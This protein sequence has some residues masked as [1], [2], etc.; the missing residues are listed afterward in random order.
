MDACHVPP[1]ISLF[2]SLAYNYF[3]HTA[4]TGLL[5]FNARYYDPAAG[6]FITADTTLS[7]GGTDP[8]ALSR[9]AYVEGN[10]LVRLDPSGH[11]WFGSLVSTVT[12]EVQ[13]AAPAA[14]AVLD[15]TTGIPSM[16]T[17]VHTIFFSTASPMDKIMAGA[18]LI[19]NVTM[20]VTMVIGVGEG[21][22]AAY[23]GAH[24]VE[25]VAEDVGA[26]ALE[27]AGEDAVA[28]T[29]EHEAESEAEHASEHA[30]EDGAEAGCGLSFAASTPVATPAGAKPIASLKTGDHVLAYDPTTGTAGTQTVTATSIHHD[31]NL[32]D[33][34][35]LV[36]DPAT[37]GSSQTKARGGIGQ[38]QTAK[39]PSTA[40]SSR[41]HDEIV[42]TTTNHPWLTTG[43]GWLPASFLQV[44]EPVVELDGTTATV[45]AIH[46][47]AGAASMWDLSVS[48]IHTFAVGIGEYVVHNC[49][50]SK[51]DF[52]DEKQIQHEYKHAKDFGVNGNYNMANSQAFRDALTRHIEDPD[53]VELT[54]GNAFGK[55]ATHY[56]C[57]SKYRRCVLC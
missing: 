16:I 21:L 30:V 51:V 2:F 3:I 13:T 27:H 43:H 49:D 14:V 15:A 17:D 37:S 50:A 26:H 36:N 57:H 25:Q 39:A 5:Y 1:G 11:D 18:D 8:W 7:G 55:P 41:T 20:D 45:E 35:L 31:D 23:V 44:G 12:H 52:S 29:V 10:P 33:V 24:I 22:R 56:Y 47:V 40:T 28:H 9:Y 32:V 6:Q 34:T 42:H 54:G 53:T 19:L 4:T 46:A 48:D 38:A